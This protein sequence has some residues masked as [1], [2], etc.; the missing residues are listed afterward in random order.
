M[1]NFLTVFIGGLLSERLGGKHFVG[2]GILMSAIAGLLVPIAAKT[3]PVLLI[4]VRAFQGAM[5]GPLIPAFQGMANKWFPIKER[6]FLV[7]ATC[8]GNMKLFPF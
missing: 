8:A 4:F 2:V 7:T 3:D 5:Q 6:N 1:G